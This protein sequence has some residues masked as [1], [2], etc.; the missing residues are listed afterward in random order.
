MYGIYW[1]KNTITNQVYIGQSTN[2]KKREKSHFNALKGGYH[3]NSKLQ[4][5]YD[6]YGEENFSFNILESADYIDPDT[7]SQME[8]KYIAKFKAYSDK[9]F[10]L[11]PGG[12]NPPKVVFTT[13]M[14]EAISKRV[15]GIGNPFYGKKHSKETIAYLKACSSK[16]TGEKNGFYGKTH[17]A[18]WKEERIAL[19]AKKKAEGWVDPKKGIKKPKDAVDV[20]KKN[21]PHR[22]Q[23]KV[24]GITYDSIADC[25]RLTGIP[26]ST[27]SKRLRL[28]SFP[29]YIVLN[30]GKEVGIGKSKSKR[31]SV[32]DVVYPSITKC[33]EALGISATS[34]TNRVHSDKFPNY[35]FV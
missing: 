19:Y 27:I 23:I 31:V 16:L 14:R 17:K 20:M 26:Y 21:M 18:N 34:V 8:I 32:D 13:E 30:E 22:K 10:N 6:K 28:A 3:E 24:D 4:R 7:L 12:T 29:L 9:G 15:S 1:I 11:T 35:K 2:L 33:S 5:S 25:A